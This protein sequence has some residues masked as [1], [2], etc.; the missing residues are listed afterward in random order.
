MGVDSHIQQLEQRHHEL[1]DRL[2]KIL[3]HPSA[4][5]VEITEIKRQKLQL[6]DRIEKL[7]NGVAYH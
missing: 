1:E 3:A 7:R 4:D 5:D 2:E 6:K